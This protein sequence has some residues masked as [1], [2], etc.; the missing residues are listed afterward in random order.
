LYVVLHCAIVG[1]YAPY[2]STRIWANLF[3][4]L[5][6]T[7]ALAVALPAT[8]NSLLAFAV[9][10]NFGHTIMFHR[11][12][13]RWIVVLIL[14]HAL[15]YTPSVSSGDLTLVNLWGLIAFVACLVLLVTSIDYMRRY[16]NELF[17]ADLLHSR[18]RHFEKF[19]WLHYFYVPFYVFA[20]LHS[21]SFVLRYCAIAAGFFILDRLVR[22][23]WGLWPRRTHS[24]SVK[25]GNMVQVLVPRHPLATYRVGSYVFVNFPGLSVFE[26]HPCKLFFAWSARSVYLTRNYIADTLSSG[27]DDDYLEMHIKALG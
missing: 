1:A 27:P 25:A 22:L 9:G 19:F 7:N 26:W 17:V 12:I 18:R 11:W 2:S 16:A 13:G 3:G 15:L 10:V 5:A 6:T 21:I 24:I 14:A 20:A 8:R 23:F 4:F